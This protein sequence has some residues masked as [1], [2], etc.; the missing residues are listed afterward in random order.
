M[1][2][3]VTSIYAAL[4]GIIIVG[5][6]FRVV[7]LRRRERIALGH[8]DNKYLRRAI[9]VH[10]NATEYIPIILILM[11]L[12]EINGG[13]TWQLHFFGVLTI[14]GRLMHAWWLSRFTGKSFGRTWGTVISWGV[15]IALAISNLRLAVA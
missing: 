5:L 11:L 9:R 3:P 15:I 12:L 1:V 4:A 13:P 10:A 2:A 7:R 14:L 6:A 8:G